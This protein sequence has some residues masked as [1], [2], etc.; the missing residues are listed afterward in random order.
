M[1][2]KVEIGNAT[3]YCGDC[4]SVAGLV[5]DASIDLVLCDL[6]YGTTACEWDA[7]IPFDELWRMY[8]RVL[9]PSR[10][11]VLFG[12]QPFTTDLIASN[13]DWFRY[14]WVWE[15]D[16]GSNFLSSKRQPMKVHEDILVFGQPDD[17]GMHQGLRD[18]FYRQKAESGL[19]NKQVNEMLGYATTGSGMAGHFF[20]N[21]LTQF[22]IPSKEDYEKIQSTG[23]FQRSYDEIVTEYM[24]ADTFPYKP[25][26]TVGTAYT[27]KQGRGSEL[28]RNKDGAV[29][30]SNDGKRFPRSVLKY[31]RDKERQHPT[32]KPVALMEYLIKTY[33]NPGDTV[34]DNCMGSGTTGVACFNLGRRFVGIEAEPKYFDNAC[35]RLID[36][37]TQP[38]LL[39]AA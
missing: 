2:E 25:Q 27:A 30:T 6:P 10:A 20:K 37:Q 32:Q 16:A 19:T 9:R 14:N 28:Y 31:G 12:S 7:I 13:R 11:V 39:P 3:L 18:Y 1:V 26:M 5:A 38:S 36:G 24:A 8:Q 4:L 35:K 23:Y 29:I 21:D 33:S 34:L 22:A 15:K 17:T